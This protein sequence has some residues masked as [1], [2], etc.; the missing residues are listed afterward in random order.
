M[1]S[2]PLLESVLEAIIAAI[3][4]ADVEAGPRVYR[5]IRDAFQPEQFAELF[6]NDLNQTHAWFIEY[7]GWPERREDDAGDLYWTRHTFDLHLWYGPYNDADET[8]IDAAIIANAVAD[9]LEG[10]ASIFTLPEITQR[11]V[12]IGLPSTEQLHNGLHHHWILSFEITATQ[13]KAA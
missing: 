3:K 10:D 11:T 4:V 7:K 13:F 1:A 6:Q 5:T 8:E 9:V 12:T 2:E